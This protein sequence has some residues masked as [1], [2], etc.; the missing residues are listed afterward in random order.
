MDMWDV[1]ET[2]ELNLKIILKVT[3]SDAGVVDFSDFDIL[4]SFGGK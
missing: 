2:R 4:L 1:S 3:D